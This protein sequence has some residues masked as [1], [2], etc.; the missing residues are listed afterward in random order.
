LSQ[1]HQE[2]VI[3]SQDALKE[4]RY[5]S[6]PQAEVTDPEG[7][8]MGQMDRESQE[9]LMKL[10]DVY[11][12]AVPDEVAKERL[13]IISADGPDAIFFAWAG[14]TKPGIGHYYRIQGKSFLI[15]F[16][17]TQPDAE[18]NPANHIHAV[19][20]DMTGDFDLPS[21]RKS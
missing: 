19:Y 3:I 6:M 2:K 12:K 7:M 15:E 17:N 4:I 20:R 9:R 5:A 18:G 8:A 21:N 10:I 1:R 13:R 16:V 11:A 14:A